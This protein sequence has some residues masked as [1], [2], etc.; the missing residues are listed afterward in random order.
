MR[1]PQG[2]IYITNEQVEEFFRNRPPQIWL[3]EKMPV[4]ALVD[5]FTPTSFE[6]YV[7]Q[8]DVKELAQIMVK[9][10]LAE[11]RRL[12]NIMIVGE[13]GLGKTS[14]AKLVVKGV[15]LEPTVIDAMSINKAIPTDGTVIIDEIHN[16]DAEVAD[17]L[18]IHLDRGR[19]T[20]IGCSTDPGALPPAFRSRFRTL[21]LD[22]YTDDELT[23]ILSK[24]S[25]RKGV[26]APSSTLRRV[27]ER[28]RNNAR[29]AINNLAFVFDLMVV[30]GQK[31]ITDT[32]V[33]D[34]F[35]KL[36]IDA[37]GYTKR[38]YKLLA[39]LP[40]D[41]PVGLQYLSAVTGIDE[42]TIEEEVEPYLMR[43]G[44]LDRTL[45]GRIKLNDI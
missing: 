37:N 28:S 38:D 10:A 30:R 19:L 34:A 27:A 3:P 16:L 9:A 24:A 35:T 42:K 41:R 29:M 31:T 1:R 33:Y 25:H 45:R 4:P 23:T 26:M 17:T 18:N 14:L 7:G 6:D 13:Y 22:N 36:N 21:V 5:V 12:P 20:I 15:G 40:F 8:T 39:A 44:K 11:K 32:L 43:T 2:A